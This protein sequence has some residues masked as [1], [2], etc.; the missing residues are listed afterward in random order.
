ML[1]QTFHARR[2]QMQNQVIQATVNP[3]LL[4]KAS[5][6]FTGTVEGR[7][8]EILQNARRAGATQVQI[9]N[10]G[11]LVVVQDN[12]RGIEDFAKLLDLGGSGWEHSLESSEDPAGVGLFCLAPRELI[13][14]SNGKML[15]IQEDGWTGKPIQLVDDDDPPQGTI[16]CFP[17][18]HWTP[19]LVDPHAAF[20]G[21]QVKVDDHE[22]PRL[23]FVS[24]SAVSYPELGCRIE[25]CNQ[26]NLGEWHRRVQHR[27]YTFD[28]VLV[29][30]HGQVVSW[31]HHPVSEQ[32]LRFL[33]ELTGEPTGIRLMLPARTRLIENEAFVALKNALEL[34]AYRFIEHRGEH[35]LPY[36]E[37][38]RA[39]DL[40]IRLPESRPTYSIGLLA[41]SE[42]PEP[43]PVEAPQN[44]PLESCYRFD[45]DQ[46][47]GND[48]DATNIHLLAALGAFATPFVPVE[49]A[50]RHNGYSWAKLSTVENVTVTVGKIIHEDWLWSEKIACVDSIVIEARTSDGRTWK[51]DV[52]MAVLPSTDKNEWAVSIVYVTQRARE[53]LAASHIWYHLG[54]WNEEGD[55][56]ETQEY[57][58]TEGLERFWA[59]VVGPDEH[60]RQRILMP[61]LDIAS[62]WDKV[63]VTRDGTVTIHFADGTDKT[64]LPPSIPPG[65]NA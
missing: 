53:L 17:D 15:R 55:T 43:M 13:I 65:G 26:Q 27:A 45:T 52:C 25:V 6:L 7:I 47:G 31:D 60:L 2:N 35:E 61:L 58:F 4:N 10:R 5:R 30:F 51:S 37:Y 38:V 54:G 28:N 24:Q 57:Q 18:M 49:I 21:L 34:E 64:L 36:K 50:S 40:G 20:G 62:D 63:Q 42:S 23:A 14:R 48:M 56:Y 11:N 44:F 41:T 16:L 39:K 9:H 1:L 33:I 12:G 19:A 32:N 46:E 3:R 59:E 22:C 8:I 29:N